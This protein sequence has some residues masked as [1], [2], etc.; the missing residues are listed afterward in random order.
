MRKAGLVKSIRGPGGGYILAKPANSITISE[1]LDSV[2]NKIKL[3]VC[4]SLQNDTYEAKYLY[5]N[6]W[7]LIDQQILIYLSKITLSDVTA[8]QIAKIKK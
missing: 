4:H 8:L 7:T 5:T 2:N 6:L 3:S 1:I